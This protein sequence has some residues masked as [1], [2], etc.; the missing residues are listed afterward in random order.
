MDHATVVSGLMPADR[1][2]FLQHHHVHSGPALDHGPS[3]R[4]ADDTSS[5]DY[6]SESHAYITL[7]FRPQFGGADGFG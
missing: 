3:R 7:R 5:H 4:E 6:E 2:F 1:G